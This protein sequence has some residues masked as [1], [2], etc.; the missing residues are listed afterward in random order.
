M[1]NLS[2]FISSLLAALLKSIFSPSKRSKQG[3]KPPTSY[4]RQR[5]YEDQKRRA[6]QLMTDG[7]SAKTEKSRLSRYEQAR[8]GLLNALEGYPQAEDADEVWEQIRLIDE[9][10]EESTRQD[11]LH[12]QTIGE[13]ITEQ[14]ESV[15]KDTEKLKT[16][17]GKLNRLRKYH[18]NLLKMDQN[19]IVDEKVHTSITRVANRIEEL[20]KE[21]SGG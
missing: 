9:K 5:F 21:I 17:K 4:T 19:E 3:Q 6:I 8:K 14:V 18:E 2:R 13:R 12:I 20:E 10:L 16:V 15:L 1:M 7:N 11:A